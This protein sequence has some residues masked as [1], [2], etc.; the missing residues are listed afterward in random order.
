MLDE[1]GLPA[2]TLR[3][4]IA[5]FTAGQAHLCPTRVD[6]PLIESLKTLIPLAPLHLPGG[7]AGIE[8]ALKLAYRRSCTSPVSI[9]RFTPILARICGALRAPEVGLYDEG[10]QAVTVFYARLSYEYVLSRLGDP[11]P[12][13]P[14]RGSPRQWREPRGDPGWKIRGHHDELHARRRYPHG[15]AIR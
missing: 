14:D 3:L 11:A 13:R 4:G 15:H 10:V 7:I 6:A 9:P 12:A 2:A 5:S 8:A 1:Q